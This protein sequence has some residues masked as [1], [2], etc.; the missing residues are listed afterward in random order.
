MRIEKGGRSWFS[1]NA[2]AVRVAIFH[3]CGCHY[4]TIPELKGAQQ[5]EQYPNW[6]DKKLQDI[7]QRDINC[8]NLF[9]LLPMGSL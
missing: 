9:A 7:I 2:V 6:E 3:H 4:H 1:H 5:S 8:S